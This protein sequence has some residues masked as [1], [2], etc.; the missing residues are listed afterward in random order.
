MT[1]ITQLAPIVDPELH[2]VRA[3]KWEAANWGSGGM[4]FQPY[5][6]DELTPLTDEETFLAA[7]HS[8]MR[9]FEITPER[10][11]AMLDGLRFDATYDELACRWIPG[12][13]LSYHE[14]AVYAGNREY[15]VYA[16]T[17]QHA[18]AFS[19]LNEI[20]TMGGPARLEGCLAAAQAYKA[21]YTS[22]HPDPEQYLIDD[23]ELDPGEVG[24]HNCLNFVRL[25][26]LV[27]RD[28]ETGELRLA[29][30]GSNEIARNFFSGEPIT[31]RA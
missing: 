25:A 11:A 1:T 22:P 14:A 18:F 15:P 2:F 6:P 7:G 13:G 28:A 26:V 27:G 3:G 31:P 10:A 21:G 12:T 20:A 4:L 30:A 24:Y 17:M 23:S 5:Y 9:G 29:T 19:A 16:A 8:E